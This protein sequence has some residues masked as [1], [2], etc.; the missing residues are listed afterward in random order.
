M[1]DIDGQFKVWTYFLPACGLFRDLFR[2]GIMWKVIK[3]GYRVL[4]KLRLF[5][6]TTLF[7]LKYF[8][9]KL[10]LAEK[11]HLFRR[12]LLKESM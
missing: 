8:P 5:Y 12:V 3:F 1:G 7:R 6:R 11:N 9:L 2:G 4:R 10:Y